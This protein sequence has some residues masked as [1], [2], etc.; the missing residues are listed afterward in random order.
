MSVKL[1]IAIPN[2]RESVSGR[3]LD[4][5]VRLTAHLAC[6][7]GPGEIEYIRVGFLYIDVAR[8]MIWQRAKRCHAESLLCIDDDMTFT[9]ETFD[10]LWSTPGDIVSALYFIRR[11]PPT[12]PCMYRKAAS[13]L[14][15]PISAYPQN[16]TLEVDAVGLGF[17]LIRKPVL[18]ALVDPFDKY[19]KKG[20][21]IVLC[22]KARAA[23]FTVTVNTAARAGHLMNIPVEIDASNAGGTV[24]SLFRPVAK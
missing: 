15:E 9:P 1:A 7:F 4:C 14:H 16:A 3:F 13:G 2:Y 17:A 24:D 10:V 20:E 22:E 18:D 12:Q 21:D 5:M 8:N 23:G 11:L 19:P 6:R